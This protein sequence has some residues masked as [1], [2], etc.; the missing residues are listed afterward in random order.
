MLQIDNKIPA[1]FMRE[2]WNSFSELY[3]VNDDTKFIMTTR[4]NKNWLASLTKFDRTP[5]QGTDIPIKKEYEDLVKVLIHPK[6]LLVI[7]WT[8][9]KKKCWK[10]LCIFLNEPYTPLEGKDFPCENC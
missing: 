1:I 10:Q 2:S 3:G 9:C 8:K 7:D 6:K 4:S 5:A